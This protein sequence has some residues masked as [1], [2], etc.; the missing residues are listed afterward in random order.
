M[1]R[2]MIGAIFWLLASA[3]TCL[4]QATPNLLTNGD[5]EL[6]TSGWTTDDTLRAQGE[7]RVEP[8]TVRGIA[9]GDLT[10]SSTRS[11]SSSAPRR[12]R[13]WNSCSCSG[14]R[15]CLSGGAVLG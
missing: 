2:N 10:G 3:A 7:F 12:A 15:T 9:T 8:D 11:T 13:T 4:A 6:G 1:R 14:P 5:F